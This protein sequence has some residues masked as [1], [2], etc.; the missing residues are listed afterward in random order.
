LVHPHPLS[1]YPRAWY[2]AGRITT[3]KGGLE[4]DE[5][6]MGPRTGELCEQRQETGVSREALQATVSTEVQ[7]EAKRT[8]LKQL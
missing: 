1:F 7:E 2:I 3:G 5:G 4:L 6:L 8:S